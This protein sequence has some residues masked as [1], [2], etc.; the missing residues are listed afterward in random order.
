MTVEVKE[1]ALVGKETKDERKDKFVAN[2]AA[3]ETTMIK[4]ITMD[5]STGKEVEE[6]ICK[7]YD[8]A[9]NND[10]SP[11]ETG[12]LESSTDAPNSHPQLGGMELGLHTPYKPRKVSK[13]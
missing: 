10:A 5:E 9:W 2:K 4:Q 13:T 12:L 7:K 8:D 11:M 1:N 6:E 3:P